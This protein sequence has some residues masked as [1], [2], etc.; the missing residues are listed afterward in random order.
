MGIQNLENKCLLEVDSKNK[1][2]MH[3]HIRNCAKNIAEEASMPPRLWHPTTD[4][5]DALLELSTSVSVPIIIQTAV[6]CLT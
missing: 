2:R 6:F 5:I 4:I 3:D 1:I